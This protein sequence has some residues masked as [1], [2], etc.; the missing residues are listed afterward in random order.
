M[1]QTTSRLVRA[2]ILASVVGGLAGC[3]S[4]VQLLTRPEKPRLEGIELY[5]R[6]DLSNAAGA[7]KNAIRQEP[8][9]Y[10]AHFYLGETY[11]AQGNYQQA[12]QE[13]KASVDSMKATL[14]GQEAIDLRQKVMNR[15]AATIARGDDQNLEKDLMTAQANNTSLTPQRRAEA[16]FLLAKVQRYRGD[17]DSAIT[18]YVKGSELDPKDFWLQKEAGIYMLQSGQKEQANAPLV[19]ASKISTHD[20]ELNQAIIDIGGL[21][22]TGS[23]PGPAT[24]LPPGQIIE[25][26]TDK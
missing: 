10:K 9:D 16:Y 21:K 2:M 22:D 20:P 6:G 26:I 17:A 19:R 7:F 15:H 3:S 13:Y 14:Q 5:N 23:V 24:K 11:E 1:K 8:R 4:D 18:A 12:I 25:P